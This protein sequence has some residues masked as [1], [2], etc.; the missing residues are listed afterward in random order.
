VFAA[1]F[2][3]ERLFHD[4][5][6]GRLLRALCL[7]F[8]ISSLTAV[9]AVVLARLMRFRAEFVIQ[10]AALAVR[11]AVAVVCALVGMGVWSLVAGSLAG[12]ASLT[13]FMAFAVRYFPRLRFDAAWL[14]AIWKTSSGYMGDTV[15]HYVN[16]NV[17]L[18]L[19]SRRF[20]AS[21]LGVYQNARSLTDEVRGR[22]AMPLQHV[23]FPAFS[24]IQGDAERLR[25]SVRRSARML[26]AIICPVGF[27]LSATAPEVVPVLYGAQWLDMIPILGLFGVSAAVRASTAI[28]WPLFNSQNRVGSMFWYSLIGVALLVVLTLL[29]LPFGLLAVA[30]AVAANSLYQIVVLWIAFTLIGLDGRDVAHALL[31]PVLASLAMWGALAALRQTL[32]ASGLHPGLMLAVL[33]PLGALIYIALMHLSSRQYGRDF[34]D[35]VRKLRER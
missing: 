31:R 25:Q 3:T 32:A 12:V 17:D 35:V 27:G 34:V 18:L 24:S 13:L 22:L 11:S 23:L 28:A 16:M 6:A 26:A 30:A 1:S 14:R 4:E 29:A 10:T 5:T 33:V 21:A 2:F 7:T 9:H 19:I 20:G 15:L 8:P